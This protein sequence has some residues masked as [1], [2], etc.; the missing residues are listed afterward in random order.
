M[1]ASRWPAALGVS[2]AQKRPNLGE[3]LTTR[4]DERSTESRI[5]ERVIAGFVD[6]AVQFLVEMFPNSLDREEGFSTAAVVLPRVRVPAKFLADPFVFS[7]VLTVVARK[8]KRGTNLCLMQVRVAIPGGRDVIR[9]C[10]I[11]EV[12]DTDAMSLKPRAAPKGI[13]R[14][15]DGGP[16][17]GCEESHDNRSLV[18]VN[19]RITQASC[20]GF[21]ISIHIIQ[22]PR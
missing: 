14:A 15:D 10:K 11:G 9:L 4:T 19:G 13:W 1:V 3:F 7:V 18:S 17:V 21:F 5:H 6:R 8:L 16:V 12:M 2:V 20:S 22:D